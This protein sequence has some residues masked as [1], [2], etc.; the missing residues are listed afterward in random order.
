MKEVASSA[1]I[2]LEITKGPRNGETFTYDPSTNPVVRIGRVVRGNTLAIKD[3][4]I[5]SKHLTLQFNP[6][7]CKWV[8]TDLDSSNGTFLN[9]C[10]VGLEPG[11]GYVI[12]DGDRVKLGEWTDFVCKVCGG[13]GVVEGC[14]GGAGLRRNPRR[15]GA[16]GE[17]KDGG[18]F[19]GEIGDGN[20]GSD[21]SRVLGEKCPPVRRGRRKGGGVPKEVLEEKVKENSKGI[22][23]SE[24]MKFGML[25]EEVNLQE[26]ERKQPGEGPEVVVEESKRRRGRRK[27]NVLTGVVVKTEPLDES[28][29]VERLQMMEDVAAAACASTRRT[30]GAKKEEKSLDKVL[31]ND[32]SVHGDEMVVNTKTRTGLRSRRKIGKNVR[33]VEESKRL[34]I[35][36][37]VGGDASENKESKD[38]QDSIQGGEIKSAR[39]LP[40]GNRESSDIDEEKECVDPSIQKGSAGCDNTDVRNETG[41]EVKVDA[42]MSDQPPDLSQITVREW[43]DW[44]EVNLPKQII[45]ETEKLFAE[46]RSKA[47]RV[48]EYRAEQMMKRIGK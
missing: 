1:G 34:D 3:S 32:G 14:D 16:L 37:E 19:L 30:R 18:M 39:D 20:G 9:G 22:M 42:M 28:I 44:L 40:D 36:E 46:M 15:R 12:R 13:G 38:I 29:E 5:S 21:G 4:G 10:S 6:D 33:V 47:R 7:S 17:G 43:L 24:S 27:D 41:S 2:T 35:I 48:K 45:A 31:E 11:K 26:R 8:L 23:D 25:K